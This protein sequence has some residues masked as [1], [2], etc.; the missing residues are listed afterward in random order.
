MLQ[1][2]HCRVHT[3]CTAGAKTGKGYMVVEDDGLVSVV[4][5]LDIVQGLVVG[6]TPV[7]VLQHVQV[8]GDGLERGGVLL[9][10]DDRV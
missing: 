2:S 1:V 8:G 5:T 7:H 6:G 10:L 3:L 4:D 9:S